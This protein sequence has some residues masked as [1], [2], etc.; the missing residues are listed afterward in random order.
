MAPHRAAAPAADPPPAAFARAAPALLESIPALM[1]LAVLLGFGAAAPR[2]LSGQNLLNILIQS[3]STGVVAI[4]MT[5]VLLTGGIDLS[6]GAV[7]L[8]TGGV[9]AKM[10]LAGA[11]LW[12][13]GV[14]ALLI[15]AACG[16]VNGAIVAVL[17]IHPFIVT[18]STLYLVRGLGLYL[19]ETRAMN[20]PPGVLQFGSARLAGIPAPVVLLA[21]V[22]VLAHVLLRRASFGLQVYATGHDAEAARRSGIRTGRVLFGVYIISGVLAAA[23]GLIS[24]AQLGA[25]SPTFG[26]QREFAAVAAAVL[27]GASLFGGRGTVFPGTVIGAVLVQTIENGLVIANADPY[28][29]PMVAAAIIFAAVFLDSARLKKIRRLR[30]RRIRPATLAQRATDA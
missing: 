9:A 11:P 24:L 12:E 14:A 19:T 22:V 4:G 3:A 7:M 2:F 16:A 6:V 26:N 27:G 25:L 29:Y 8:L 10:A 15:G 28:V 23:G 13:A 20:L 5:F 1:L 30:V 18:L 17:R 21:V